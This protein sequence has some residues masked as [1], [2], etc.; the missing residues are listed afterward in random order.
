MVHFGDAFMEPADGLQFVRGDSSEATIELQP[1][2]MGFRIQN[3]TGHITEVIADGQAERNG[4]KVG[5]SI[6]EIDKRPYSISLLRQ[7]REGHLPY[8]LTLKRG[9]AGYAAPAHS[10]MPVGLGHTS[11]REWVPLGLRQM[12]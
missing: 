1:G 5:W 3:D 10:R 11:K 8:T 4:V 7:R 12:S 9:A 6:V 2:L